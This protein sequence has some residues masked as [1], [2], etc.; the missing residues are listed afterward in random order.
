[1]FVLQNALEIAADIKIVR[2][3]SRSRGRGVGRGSKIPIKGIIRGRDS[4]S[5]TRGVIRGPR[6]PTRGRNTRL[7]RVVERR[8]NSTIT[9]RRN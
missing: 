2:A 5:N 6:V 8:L 4:T 7:Q 9:H 1:M 3:I